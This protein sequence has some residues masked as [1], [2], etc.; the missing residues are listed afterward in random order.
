MEKPIDR[1][2]VGAGIY[3]L[4]AAISLAKHNYVTLVLDGDT[5]PFLRSSYINQARIHKGY[6]YPRSYSTAAKSARY[7]KRFID[8]YSDCIFFDFDQIYALAAHY[9]WTN[10][11][12]F[13]RFCSNVNIRCDEIT[14]REDMLNANTIDKAFHTHEFTFD[15]KLI[16][17][18]MYREALNL[19]VAF[20]FGVTI[21]TVEARNGDYRVT[22]DSGETFSAPWILNATYAGINGIHQLVG[23]EPFNIKYVLCEVILCHVSDNMSKVGVTVMDGPF[24]SLM[25]F[26]KSG[27][28]SLTSVSKTP[29]ITSYNILPTFP[30]QSRNYACSPN[31]MQN[32]NDCAYHPPT[33][34]VEMNQIARK[35]LNPDIKIE[36]IKSLFTLK[37]ILKASEIDDGR[38]TLIRQYSDNP[39]FYS[40]FSGKINTIYDLDVI[41]V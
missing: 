31:R 20:M 4:Y 8:D 34:F 14:V 9:S 11:D 13:A 1:I 12:Q 18:K 23:F 41:L 39:R 10:G 2:V 33:A 6:H 21:V 32:C 40:V 22:V 3:G 5:A 35:Y 30:C 27:Y 24:F 19:G 26:G 36:Y 7:F 16:G 37:P 17:E 29:H 28:H 25:P 38:P 15:A